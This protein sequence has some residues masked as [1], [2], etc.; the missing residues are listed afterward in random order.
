MARTRVILSTLALVLLV[1]ASSIAE[2]RKLQDT[3]CTVTLGGGLDPIAGKTDV[4]LSHDCNNG[5]AQTQVVAGELVDFYRYSIITAAFTSSS[6]PQSIKHWLCSEWLFS[7]SKVAHACG[8]A[9]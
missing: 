4:T 7:G 5:Y 6:T 8:H 3:L 2:A 9:L 1:A